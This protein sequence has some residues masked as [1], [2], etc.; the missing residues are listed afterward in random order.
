MDDLKQYEELLKAHDWYYQYS[1][2]HSAWR[3]GQSSISRLRQ[4]AKQSEEHLK[5]FREYNLKMTQG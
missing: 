1:D 5:M 2:D 4:M 3:R